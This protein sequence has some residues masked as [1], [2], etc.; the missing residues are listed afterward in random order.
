MAFRIDS[1]TVRSTTRTPQGGLRCDARLTR[2]GVLPYLQPD[3]SIIREYR[4]A[5]EVFRAD[6]LASLGF[7]PV[8]V[9][10][11]AGTV[12]PENFAKLSV[13]Y[14]AGE[15]KQDGDFVA[16]PVM[17]QD[18]RGLKAIDAG[19]TE[20]SCGYRCDVEETSGVAPNG[21]EF[22]RIQRNIV[23]NHVAIVRQGRA[24]SAVSLRLDSAGD[25]IPGESS[26]TEAEIAAL[27]ARADKA[28]KDLAQAQARADKAEAER[29]AQTAR[30]D[31]ALSPEVMRL[32]VAARTALETKGKAILGAE[33]KADASDADLKR[34]VAQKAFPA[35]KLDGKSQAYVEALFDSAQAPA[36][37]RADAGA[38]ELAAALAP[39]A[40]GRQDAAVSPQQAQ[41]AAYKALGSAPLTVT[42]DGK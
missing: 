34:A 30:A 41:R 14:L 15:A 24:G 40:A 5:E 29:D 11:P 38:D 37:E 21:E 6:S 1:G 10:H 28:E 25:Q 16:A 2:V 22:D 32:A 18:A 9:T 13:G 4:P 23:Y 33:F 3:G 12:G 19:M 42:K 20:L 36:A 8:T 27:K 17:V 7:A 35:L 39:P 31:A 26:M